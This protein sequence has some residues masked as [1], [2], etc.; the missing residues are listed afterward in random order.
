[1]ASATCLQRYWEPS[2]DGLGVLLHPELS[3]QGS[4][5]SRVRDAGDGSSAAHS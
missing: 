1:V 5:V 4:L 2:F 3:T